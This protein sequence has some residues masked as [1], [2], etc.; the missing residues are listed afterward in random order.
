MSARDLGHRL[1]RHPSKISR[2]EHGR[3]IPTAADIRA[4]CSHCNAS[5]QEVDLVASLHSVEGMYIEWQ[6]LSRAGMRR[7]QESNV[8]LYE[9]T[10]L[11]RIY[12][13]G[14]VPGVFQTP[15]YARSRI[16]H[17]VEF[18]GV[19]DHVEQVVAARM[20][21]QG[22][23]HSGGRRIVAVLEEWALWARLGTAEMMAGQLGHLINVAC[24]PSVSLGIIPRTVER[25][26]WQSPGF[27]IFDEERV[28]VETPTAELTIT[29]PR[30]VAIYIRTFAE[31]T[32]MAVYGPAARALITEAIDA[33]G[34]TYRDGG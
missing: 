16:S 27:W 26:M 7:I 12:E 33:L 32:S 17:I 34:D 10:R 21:R 4:W 23:A 8:P 24:W 25:T 11:F 2:I 19:E 14:V 13:P 1:G 30:E 28:L 9:R 20:K 5:Q 22:L 29:Q 3:A 18:D 31:F 6:R 15:A